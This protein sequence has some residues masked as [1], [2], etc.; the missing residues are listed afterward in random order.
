M[1]IAWLL[2]GPTQVTQFQDPSDFTFKAARV[3]EWG[4]GIAFV[5]M[6]VWLVRRCIR[7][8]R[9]IFDA[10]LF[11]AGICVI[12]LD[13][14]TN[15]VAPI[16]LYNSNFT[17][18]A[19][20]TAYI[21]GVINPAM[22]DMPFPLL[23]HAFNYPVALLGA[24]IVVSGVL[25]QLRRRFPQARIGVLLLLC[26]LFG[27]A[28]DFVYELFMMRTGMWAFPG[29]PDELSLWGSQPNKF[30]LLE[31]LPA[32]MAFAT[33]GALRFFRNDRGEHLSERGVANLPP[34]WRTTVSLL[35]TIAVV[36][37]VWIVLCTIQVI[38][39]FYA[40]PYKPLSPALLANICDG[41]LEGGGER[42]GTPYGPCPEQGARIPIRRYDVDVSP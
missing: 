28:F 33:F 31:L 24:A 9:L 10:K 13:A 19:P 27:I 1:W 16:W 15:F 32:G 2:D 41:P 21:P 7:E 29:T 5:A 18:V 22:K 8:R 11:I 26:V 25:T 37:L 35:A 42:V 39:G 23:F 38:S 4:M 14:W 6:V 12:W 20:P 17:N 30:P 34:R 36:N 3:M 40:D